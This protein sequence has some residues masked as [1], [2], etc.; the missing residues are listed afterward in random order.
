MVRVY[1]LDN[2]TVEDYR[3]LYQRGTVPTPEQ[4]SGLLGNARRFQRQ[5]YGGRGLPKIRS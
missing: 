1:G 4:L 2:M 3:K 5:E